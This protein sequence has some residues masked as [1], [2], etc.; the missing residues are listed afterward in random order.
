MYGF[1]PPRVSIDDTLA[2]LFAAHGVQL[3]L[4]RHGEDIVPL[5]PRLGQPF[6]LQLDPM[7][8]FGNFDCCISKCA[9][10][11]RARL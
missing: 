9:S 3:H 5:V 4:Y 8:D 1:E 7:G 11:D 6:D 2:A 10:Q